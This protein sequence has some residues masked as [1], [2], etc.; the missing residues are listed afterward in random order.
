RFIWRVDC[1]A[2]ISHLVSNQ[3]HRKLKRRRLQISRQLSVNL[4]G[5]S[6]TWNLFLDHLPSRSSS[7][8]T[9]RLLDLT[10]SRTE[11]PLSPRRD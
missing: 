11:T 1:A 6:V 9:S 8:K 4:S 7:G 2:V 10:P 5:A 3:A